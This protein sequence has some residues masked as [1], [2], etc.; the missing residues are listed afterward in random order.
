MKK[1][2]LA[3]ICLALGAATLFAGDEEVQVKV[4]VS[5]ERNSLLLK[6]SCRQKAQKVAVKK[7]LLKQNAQMPEKV[8]DEA[9]GEYRKFID[10]EP[11]V[12]DESFEDGELVGE[13]TVTLLQDELGK[14]LQSKGVS[15]NVAADGTK[16]EIV[17]MEEPPDYGAMKV[18]EAFG[19]GLGK[20]CFFFQRYQMFQRRIRDALVKKAGTFGFEVILLEDNEAYEEF[21]KSDPVLVGVHFDP[22]VGENGDFKVTPNFVKT[23]RDNNPDTLVLY[24]RI[25]A[26]AF[27]P[28]TQ[29][30]RTTVALNIKNLATG[31]TSSLGSRDFAAVTSN[32]QQD[33]LMADFGS[34]V[35]KAMHSLLNG[36]D[37]AAKIQHIIVSMRNAAARPAGPMKVVINCSKIDSKIRTRA[38]V[39]LKKGCAA[40]KLC[41]KKDVKIRGNTLSFTVT[42][43][44]I[45]DLDELWLAVYEVL[46]EAGIEAT[47]DQKTT[48]GNTLTVTPGK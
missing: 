32:T 20:G 17:I 38:R 39:M 26:L 48:N 2:F 13:Y 5:G 40:K 37:M 29:T 3:V 19:T 23:V 11:D 10:E 12:E 6:R 33:M 42:N 1:I 41:D 46:D 34:C 47:D 4:S 14:W 25:D 30:I 45:P 31:T 8:I 9:M 22:S 44:E 7:Y 27:D 18:A 16:T 28:S 36:E 24:Y 15:A 43:K 21:K 35:E